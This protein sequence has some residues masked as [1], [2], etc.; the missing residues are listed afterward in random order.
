MILYKL[1]NEIQRW[2]SAHRGRSP[3]QV[4]VPKAVEE[5][6]SIEMDDWCANAFTPRLD[7]LHICGVPVVV[8]EA[9]TLGTYDA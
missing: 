6:L 5:L 2:T 9:L 3:K 4:R 8:D 1:A 7:R